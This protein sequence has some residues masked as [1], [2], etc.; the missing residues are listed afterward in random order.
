[1]SRERVRLCLEVW[2][3]DFTPEIS[4][5]SEPA[6]APSGGLERSRRGI[7][8]RP[9]VLGGVLSCED[10]VLLSEAGGEIS[11]DGLKNDRRDHV[12]NH[13]RSTQSRV[14]TKIRCSRL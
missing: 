7:D 13:E 6:N 11:P 10:M 1:M 2:P 4:D 14:S 3:F 12:D 8:C 5:S 9:T